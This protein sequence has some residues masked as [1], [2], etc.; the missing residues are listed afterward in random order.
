[1]RFKGTPGLFV[2]DSKTGTKIGKFDSKGY[3]EV[4]DERMAARMQ[5]RFA[6]AQA[7]Q[8]KASLPKV[9]EVINHD[10]KRCI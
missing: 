3:L 5:K 8:K 7:K 9:K 4:K 6:P 1:M 2:I 10:S